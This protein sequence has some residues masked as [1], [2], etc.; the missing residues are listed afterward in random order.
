MKRISQ[1]EIESTRAAV[2]A[3]FQRKGKG[4]LIPIAAFA[5]V[6]PHYIGEFKNGTRKRVGEST[7]LR[8]Q[9]F[10][11]SEKEKAVEY[12]PQQ[13]NV[14]LSM[15][16]EDPPVMDP[17]RYANPVDKTMAGLNNLLLM[18]SDPKVPQTAKVSYLRTSLQYILDNVLPKEPE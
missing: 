14:P 13:L 1:E 18:A 6:A 10:L 16:R 17:M 9:E 8:I 5:D 12:P 3:Y 4:S 15:L 11:E 2:Q 7:L